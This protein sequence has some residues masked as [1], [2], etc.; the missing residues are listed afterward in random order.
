MAGTAETVAPP[1][2]VQDTPVLKNLEL[3]LARI[4]NLFDSPVKTEEGG[5]EQ[6]S[7]SPPEEEKGDEEEG[8]AREAGVPPYKGSLFILAIRF[9][10]NL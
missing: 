2:V 1:D 4:S 8:A 7:G 9:R 3:F 5:R 10:W 6:R